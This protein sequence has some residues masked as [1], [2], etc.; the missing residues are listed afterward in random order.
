MPGLKQVLA[1]YFELD[2]PVDLPAESHIKR[3]IAIDFYC[4]Q[5]VGVSK[6]GVERE[7]VRQVHQGTSGGVEFFNQASS[8]LSTL[9]LS[10][11]LERRCKFMSSHVYEPFNRHQSRSLTVAAASSP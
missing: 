1:A 3:Q 8:V 7:S 5:V 2:M 9:V 11:L 10:V 6:R 4:R